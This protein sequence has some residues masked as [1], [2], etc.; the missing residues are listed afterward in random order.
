MGLFMG[1]FVPIGLVALAHTRSDG[2][3]A[4][5]VAHLPSGGHMDGPGMSQN[6]P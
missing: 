1:H 3:D 2:L 6:G 5:R 4:G